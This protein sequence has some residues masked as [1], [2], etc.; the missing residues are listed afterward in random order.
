[1][2]AKLIYDVFRLNKP[3]RRP[4]TG[5]Q[6]VLSGKPRSSSLTSNHS[7]WS[8]GMSN[9]YHPADDEATGFLIQTKKGSGNNE[10]KTEYR[11]YII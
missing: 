10:K 1:M 4:K 7:S 9:F 2:I 11:F 5:I 8:S 3:T 6:N